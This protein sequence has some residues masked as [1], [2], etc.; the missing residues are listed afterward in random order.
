ME[1]LKGMSAFEVFALEDRETA[2]QNAAEG[3]EGSYEV[4]GR[5]KDATTSPMKLQV[6]NMQ[7]R[8][9]CVRVGAFQDITEKKLMEEE[10]RK[11][12]ALY[13]QAERMGKLGYWEWDEINDRMISCSAQFARIYDMTVDEA[14]AFFSSWESDLSVI[15]PDDRE[16][17]KK[18][19]DE[20]D[21][22]RD[23][24]DIEFRIVTRS[25][26]VRH[27]HLL[28]E[29]V[30]DEQ[31]E[32]I[33]SFGTEQDITER[34]RAEEETKSL[35]KFPSENPNPVLRI[36]PSGIL[37]YANEAASAV[38]SEWKLMVGQAT[39][40]ALQ[41]VTQDA[42]EHRVRRVDIPYGES[43][44]S[45]TAAFLPEAK[46]VNVYANDISARKQAEAALAQRA[47]VM[48]ALYKTSL[49]VNA[50]P[51]LMT[52]L[53]SIVQR[54]TKLMRTQKGA[55]SLFLIRLHG[56]TL[57]VMISHNFEP[58]LALDEL[59]LGEGLAG[60][61]AQYGEALLI[62]D[63]ARWEDRMP[64][65]G[66]KGRALGLPL[67]RG[68]HVDGVL[69]MGDLDEPDAFDEAEVQ[70]L[71]LFANQ[72]AIAIE[73]ARLFEAEQKQRVLAEVLRETAETLSQS[74]ELHEV[75]DQILASAQRI[76][77]HDASDITLIGDDGRLVVVRHR[78]FEER[79][80]ADWISQWQFSVADTP[81]SKKMAQRDTPLIISDTRNHELWVDVPQMRWIRSF[82][83]MPI[84]MR[85]EFVGN[86]TLISSVPD[87]FLP[88][89][90]TPLQAFANQAA[91][92]IGNA[93]LFEELHTSEENVRITLD[94]I[95]DAVI[96]TD[97]Q[98]NIT[99][100]N[101]VAESLTGWTLAEAQ[102]KA[103]T[104]VF[105]T[106]NANIN[107]PAINPVEKVIES[108]E[109]VGLGNDT[110][111]IARDGAKYQIAESAAP[112]KGRRGD[113]EGVVLVFRVLTQEY[114]MRAQSRQQQ[115][116][117][118][119]GTLAGGVAHEINNPINVIMN[120]GQLISDRLDPES[121]LQEFAEGIGQETERVAQIVR[122]L[123]A[124]ARHEKQSH[125]P[126][127]IADIVN[128]TISLI[129][130]IIRRDQITLEVDVPADLPKFKCRS[131]QIQQVLMNL[132]TNARD[133]LNE[134][135]PEYD[136]D[137]RIA[138]TVRLCEKEGRRWL[139]TTVENHG[140]GIP[141]E[142]RERLF[143]PFFT[144]KDRTK[145]TG[146][147][148][149]ISHGIVQDHHGELSF[150]SVRDQYTRFYLDLPVD[151]G[152][153]LD[154]ASEE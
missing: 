116:L 139:R 16:R 71:S 84:R 113:I 154:E 140:A 96:A 131:Q 53:Q 24:M 3:K 75:L 4:T 94:S 135:Y 104:E 124:F 112:I 110:V 61:V 117:E 146:L 103:L 125:S 72:A 106:I 50:Q 141:D 43:I 93:R 119:I 91:V 55:G 41:E 109:M 15:H 114:Q 1:E 147:G 57:K 138:L 88:E 29:I 142:I 87:H 5:R 151:N 38:F 69:I 120:H 7:Y 9:T 98:G 121:P 11:S 122:N 22:Q 89:H 128:D 108:G 19:F 12:Q 14:L 49:E 145:G 133:A 118:S 149:S 143:D 77:P 73:N 39:P 90:G 92:A 46:Y 31:G 33:K 2:R 100:M 23:G 144:T 80:L 83:A 115:K 70:L 136:P 6:R 56:R 21:E 27:I 26:T 137:K 48:E 107:E 47:E 58:P 74:L 102:G 45:V 54:A 51:D 18:H 28:S 66:W 97:T 130:T 44:F 35:A 127:N 42:T 63:Y 82:M 148:L 95:G 99:S 25:G 134:R 68:K 150:E 79:G 81:T 153:S 52:L 37:L 62:S 13:R 32:V 10:L 65:A 67:K 129:C 85:D 34:K 86:I 30:L 152:W 36:D 132:L 111:L 126:A 40:E 20:S 101:P 59:A 17:F 78:G 76:I 60:R 123:L 105:Y 64:E 8:D